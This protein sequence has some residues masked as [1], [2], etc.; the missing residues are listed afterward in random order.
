MQQPLLMTKNKLSFHPRFYRN[1]SP[2]P[3]LGSVFEAY[4]VHSSSSNSACAEEA[5][6]RWNE[7]VVVAIVVRMIKKKVLLFGLLLF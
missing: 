5:G 6:R 1:L 7:I 2:P 3:P 4:W